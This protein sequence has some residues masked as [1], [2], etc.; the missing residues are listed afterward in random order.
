MMQGGKVHF[1]YTF[2][3]AMDSRM[4]VCVCVRVSE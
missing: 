1:L 4:D 2:F 3:Q